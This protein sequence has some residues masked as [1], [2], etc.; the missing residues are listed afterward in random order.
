MGRETR[1]ED[2]REATRPAKNSERRMVTPLRLLLR[3]VEMRELV[4]FLE[5]IKVRFTLRGRHKGERDRE[6]SQ[7]NPYHYEAQIIVQS[8]GDGNR[9]LRTYKAGGTGPVHALADALAEFLTL[10]QCD[11]HDYATG[12]VSDPEIDGLRIDA[13]DDRPGDDDDEPAGG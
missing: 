12:E 9:T 6:R 2:D 7:A 13:D 3:N 5:R 10:E 8:Y 4:A 1:P 11:F